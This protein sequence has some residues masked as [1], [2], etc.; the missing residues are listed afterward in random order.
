MKKI[1]FIVLI[2]VQYIFI[3]CSKTEIPKPPEAAKTSNTSLASGLGNDPS[4]ISGYLYADASRNSTSLYYNLTT[5]AAFNEPDANLSAGF[6]HHTDNKVSGVN[7][8]GN[9]SVGNTINF[10]NHPLFQVFSGTTPST[11]SN[12]NYFGISS[13][14]GLAQ[15]SWITPG[16]GPFKP[17]NTVISR[18]F[19]V[20]SDTTT[21]IKTLSASIA[22]GYTLAVINKIIN[23]DSLVVRLETTSANYVQKTF[24]PGEV[25]TFTTAEL[26]RFSSQFSYGYL[27]L[28]AY[29][30]SNQTIS[31]KKYLFELS[32]KAKNFNFYF[33]P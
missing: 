10:S 17:L 16:N 5:Y 6:N 15:P 7:I 19:P 9:I 22:K 23:Y 21:S 2:L 14:T 30:Y 18:G 27:S 31:D 25:V 12:V 26:N 32:T 13:I 29:N 4:K 33:Y 1:N 11:S 8:S 24:L 3:S 20:I 28:Y